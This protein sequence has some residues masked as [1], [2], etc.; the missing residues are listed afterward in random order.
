[1]SK[2]DIVK[3]GLLIY[4]MREAWEK[5]SE[6]ERLCPRVFAPLTPPSDSDITVGD[7]D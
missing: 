1:M 5:V 2:E 7:D 6:E 4:G 3:Y